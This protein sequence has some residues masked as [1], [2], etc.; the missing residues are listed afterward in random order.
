MEEVKK[1]PKQLSTAVILLWASLA[2]GV[3]KV[4]TLMATMKDDP[5]KVMG[6]LIISLPIILLM[7]WVIYKIGK[8]KDWAR[9]VY[10]TLFIIGVTSAVGEILVYLSIN[11][12]ISTMRLGDVLLSA[13][14][15]FILF[16]DSS[17]KYFN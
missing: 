10:L 1:L 13:I 8:G 12:I 2:L 9:V 16:K 11:P 6:L 14:G 15:I 4:I 17:A 5:E 7:A 3:A